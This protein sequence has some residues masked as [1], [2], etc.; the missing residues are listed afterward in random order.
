M[1]DLLRSISLTFAYVVLTV[2]LFAC[3]VRVARGPSL[4]DRVL[5]VDLMTVVGAGLMAVAAIS[6]DDSVFLDVALILIV[7][8]F[9]GT[10][11]FAQLIERQYRRPPDARPPAEAAAEKGRR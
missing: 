9:V 6:F 4:A 8:G 7:T 10:A 3:L 2:G 5:A 11:A 1:T